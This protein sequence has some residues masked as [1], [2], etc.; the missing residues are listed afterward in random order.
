MRAYRLPRLRKRLWAVI[1]VVGAGQSVLLAG[2]ATMNRAQGSSAGGAFI[3]AWLISLAGLLVTGM[4]IDRRLARPLV[5]T[6]RG[7]D[8]L[9]SSNPQHHLEINGRHW[10]DRLPDTLEQLGSALVRNQQDMDEAAQAVATKVEARRTR[11]E[12]ILR[13]I[14]DG[15]MVCDREGRIQLYNRT[16][17]DLLSSEPALGLGRN[18]SEVLNE[19]PLNHTLRLLVPTNEDAA[20]ADAELVCA[21]AS[22]ERLLRCRVARLVTD[23]PETSGFVMTLQDVSRQTRETLRR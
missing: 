10:L 3:T 17:R 6:A 11:L 2:L 7:A 19:G 8:I 23:D 12:T 1:G 5:A 18:I 4:I 22:G 20:P 15:V 13:E 16:T 14:R 21:T 9:A